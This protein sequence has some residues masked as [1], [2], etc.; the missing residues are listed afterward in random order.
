MNVYVVIR[1][2]EICGIFTVPIDAVRLAGA[3]GGRWYEH[4]SNPV[5]PYEVAMGYNSYRVAM[6]REG[7]LNGKIFCDNYRNHKAG[8]QFFGHDDPKYKVLTVHVWAKT[9]Q[10]AREYADKIRL[11][12]IDAG[13]WE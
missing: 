10:E 12:L 6:W 1:D 3:I 2:E 11:E 4:E 13:K 7:Q 9:Q 8:H 5:P